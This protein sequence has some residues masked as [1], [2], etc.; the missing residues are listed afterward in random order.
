MGLIKRIKDKLNYMDKVVM[1]DVNK[2]PVEYQPFLKPE[3]T[4]RELSQFGQLLIKDKLTGGKL[5]GKHKKPE[6]NNKR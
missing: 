6:T 2:Y 1:V 5:F 3:M 4:N